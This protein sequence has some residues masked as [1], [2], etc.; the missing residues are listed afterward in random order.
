[1]ATK[2]IPYVNRFTGDVKIVT[3]GGAKKLSEDWSRVEFTKNE[4]GVDVM[5]I[6]LEGATVDVSENETQQE[7]NPDG[8]GSAE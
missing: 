3:R 6:Q 8:I 4:A 1:M 2:K 5:R 7:V